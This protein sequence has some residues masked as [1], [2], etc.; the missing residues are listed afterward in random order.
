MILAVVTVFIGAL[1]LFDRG[2]DPVIPSKPSNI[3]RFE[4]GEALLQAFEDAQES[5]SSFG[6]FR[7]FAQA[8]GAMVAESVTGTSGGATQKSY[9]ETNVQVEG[10]D[11]ADIIK[12]DGDY[13]YTIS[14][15]NLVIISAYPADEAEILSTTKFEGFNPNEIFIHGDH[16]M[17][18]GQ[19]SYSFEVGEPDKP[20]VGEP[21]EVGI[22]M[23]EDMMIAPGYYPH[24]FSTVSVRLYDVSDKEDPELL[25]D[26]DF[27]GSYLTSRKIGEDVY[28]VVNTYPRHFPEPRPCGDIMPLYRD[29]DNVDV[30]QE[31]F[32]AI[33]ACT[34]VGYIMPIQAEQFI[35]IASMSITDEDA[36]VNKEVIVGSGQNVYASL[37][38]LYV[39]Q[40]TWPRYTMR[41]ELAEDSTQ[42]TVISKFELDDGDVDFIAKGEVKGDILN[43]FSMD[44]YD[45]HFR[46]ATTISGY[47]NNVDTSTNNMYVLD[48]D[49]DVVGELEGVAPGESIYSVRFMGKRGY[50]VTF[51]HIDPLFVID[52]SDPTDPTILGK[53]KIPGYSDYLHPYDETHLIGIGKEVD[54]SIDADKVHTEGAVYY[55]A[56]QGV[57]L[58]IFDVSDVEHPIEMYKEV[59]GDRGTES[60]ATRD[61]KAFLFDKEKGLLVVP[62]LVAELAEGQDKSMQGDY[63][64]QGAYVYDISLKDGFEL[65]GRVTHYDDDDAFLKSGYYFR[66]DSSIRRS[67]YIEDVLYT[68]SNSRLQMNDLDDLDRLNYV[69]FEQNSGYGYV[70][71][72]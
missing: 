44:E 2:E 54:A 11:E 69:E 16:L 20:N 55:T 28:F 10:V 68:M 62:M 65:R 36:D 49:M 25:R 70:D 26:V 22:S 42:M 24:Y 51:R 29:A 37:S 43:Q 17:V 48:E 34:D 39:A 8:D 46:I 33:A 19:A 41:G 23:E 57:K 3:N 1:L 64:F 52:L 7:T 4:S 47:S 59:I 38:N 67:L 9:S 50:M 60:E 21:V 63:T 12:T 35:T 40:T 32:V 53:L 6:R 56:I 71:K 31:D 58:A 13:I 66:G 61:H 72:Y 27:E 15:S 45:E 30:E 14:N 5:G 18:F